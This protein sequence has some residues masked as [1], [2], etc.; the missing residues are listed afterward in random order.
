MK[1]TEEVRNK[2][3]AVARRLMVQQGYQKTTIRQIVRETG[4]ASGSIY[5]LFGGKE[6]ILN[7]IINDLMERLMFIIESE[8][9]NEDSLFRYA[10]ILA[11]E[12]I[13]IQY[14]KQVREIYYALFSSPDSLEY[15]VEKNMVL[16]DALLGKDSEEERKKRYIQALLCKGA[17]RA[18]IAAFYFNKAINM[19]ECGA[20][21]ILLTLKSCNT[22]EK[23]LD[24]ILK[25]LKKNKGKFVDI[26]QKLLYE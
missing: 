13:G 21:V 22:R 26:V 11:V 7:E 20:Q 12:M 10:A 15:T 2:V 4:V 16:Q 8:F 14:N 5:Y 17:L 1:R 18:Y 19:D 3:I 6:G 24:N 25:K 23:E 9:R